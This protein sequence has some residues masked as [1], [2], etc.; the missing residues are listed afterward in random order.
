MSVELANKKFL[1]ID[2][3][4]TFRQAMKKMLV[5]IDAKDIDTADSGENAIKEMEMKS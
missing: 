5:S 1:A 2:D 4:L 3:F